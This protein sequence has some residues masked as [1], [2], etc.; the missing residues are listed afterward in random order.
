MIKMSHR[1]VRKLRAAILDWSGTTMDKYVL[2]P[3]IVFQK[4]FKNKRIPISMKEARIPMGLRKDLHIKAITEIPSVRQRWHAYYGCDPN[5]EDVDNMFEDFVPLQLSCLKEYSQLLPG[6]IDTIAQLRDLNLKI[7]MTTGFSRDM[8]DILLKD[9]QSQGFVP[10]CNVAGDEVEKARPSPQ[11][12][13][14]NLE[15]LG[16]QPSE[17]VKVDDTIG[18]IGEGIAAGCWTVGVSR[19]SNYMNIDS[20]EHELELSKEELDNRNQKSREMLR[21]AGAHYVI[22]SITELPQIVQQ[23]NNKFYKII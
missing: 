13:L 10:D 7:G 1:Y 3:A 19:Y 14:K 12:V 5:Q 6:V 9:A 2:A 23:I 8:V 17:V 4:V 18:G 15:L 16:V 21:G 22:D 11:M 20:F